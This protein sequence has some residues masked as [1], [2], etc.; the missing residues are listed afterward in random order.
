MEEVIF[1]YFCKQTT[2]DPPTTLTSLPMQKK[3]PT[4]IYSE[5]GELEGVIIH[6]PGKEVENM[7]PDNAE[8]ALYSDILNLSVA[9]KE[10]NEFK[11]VLQKVTQTFEVRDLLTQ[12]LKNAKVREGLIQQVCR[13]EEAANICEELTQLG[14]E[15]LADALIQGVRIQKNSLTNYLNK[16]RFALKPLHN[17]FF[18]RDAAI[19]VYDEVLVG[20][21]A[22]QVRL[23]ESI[24]MEAIFDYH[25]SF[26]T[27]TINPLRE[28]EYDK[29]IAIEGG[30]VLVA[31]EEILLCGIGSRT[32]AQG[33]DFLLNKLKE[34][35]EKQHILIQELPL[36]P[37]S[38]IHLDMVFTLL[39]RDLCM[40]YEPIIM[41]MN[42]YQTVHIYVEGGKVQFIR[43]IKNLPEGLKKLGMDLQPVFCGD[44]DD[45]W[46]Q[47]REQWHSGANFFA[48]G[49]GK[50]IGYARNI[51]TLNALHKNGF[52]II[53]ARDVLKN[54]VNLQDHERYVVTIEGSELPRGGG[55]A[56]CMTMPVSRKPLS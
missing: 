14:E 42:K 53:R 55:G 54:K 2:G 20:A 31:N 4:H 10:Y 45:Q 44:K 6:S 3:M 25:P 41:K 11:G 8:R 37:E 33:V 34:K 17:F 7:T 56:R 47:E 28:R 49:P 52:E 32:T 12:I 9:S 19:S 30:D 40:I 23:R 51:H 35:K 29:G 27:Q 43:E 50:I 39:D 13:H 5:I 46:L 24:I 48:M 16:E 38:F 1:C 36:T 15:A 26:N 18:T 22:S 21:M